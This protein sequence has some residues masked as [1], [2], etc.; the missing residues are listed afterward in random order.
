MRGDCK[1]SKRDEKEREGWRET[2]LPPSVQ[3]VECRLNKRTPHPLAVAPDPEVYFQETHS[4]TRL[5]SLNHKFD[6]LD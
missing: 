6:N 3:L 4:L 5:D 1:G 2:G